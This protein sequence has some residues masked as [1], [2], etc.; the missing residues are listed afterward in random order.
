MPGSPAPHRKESGCL[1]KPLGLLHLLRSWQAPLQNLPLHRATMSTQAFGNLRTT[2]L[3]GAGELHSSV[4]HV[5]STVATCIHRGSPKPWEQK[6]RSKMRL[7]CLDICEELTE[8]AAKKYRCLP[9]LIG[10]LEKYILSKPRNSQ[11]M[12][13]KL[14]QPCLT[15]CNPMDSSPPGSSVHRILQARTLE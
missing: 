15:L 6:Q 4:L 7:S 12:H 10:E 13:A 9:R 11:Y 5:P 3:N 1:S 8:K 2:V 14:L